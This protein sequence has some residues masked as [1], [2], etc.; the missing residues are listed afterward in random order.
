MLHVS[1]SVVGAM[2]AALV[3]V[4]ASLGAQQ[5]APPKIA[6]N[7]DREPVVAG[8][9]F[10]FSIT[11]ETSGADEPDIK[12]PLL[13]NMRILRQ[14]ESHPMSLSFSFGL[15]Q[16][17]QAYRSQQAVYRYVLVADNPGRYK[18]DPV[19]VTVGG[20]RYKSEPF[21]IDVSAGSGSP[22]ARGPNQS[23][24]GAEPSVSGVPEVEGET[25]EGMRPNEEYV[26]Q[27]TASKKEAVVGEKIVV[28]VVA[29]AA[30]TVADLEI[31]R[32]PGTEGFW[33]E[34]LL[35]ANRRVGTEQVLV[36]GR[37]FARV[38]MRRVAV[39]P[40]KPGK[41]TIEPAVG[42]FL[43]SRGFFTSGK[44]FTRTSE[45]IVIDVSPLPEK[46]R[47][48]GF[49]PANVGRFEFGVSV[50]STKVKVG[51]PVTVT[52]TVRG[53]GNLRSLVLPELGDVAGFKT[54]EPET[55][56]QVSASGT[57]VTGIRTVKTLMIAKEPGT[58]RIL[59]LKWSYFDPEENR[60]VTEESPEV[61]IEVTPGASSLQPAV[62]APRERREVDAPTGEERLNRKLR[63]IVSRSELRQDG[64]RPPMASGWFWGLA[65]LG[66][67]VYF[68]I[69]FISRTRRRL[70][71]AEIKG[72]SKRADAKALRSL[73]AL[74][75]KSSELDAET[76]FAGLHKI[77]IG[78]LEARLET[79]VAGDTMAEL[80][81]RL[82]RRGFSEAQAEAVVAELE[83]WDFARFARSA[84]SE[85]ERRQSGARLKELVAEMA[86]VK[87]KNEEA[88]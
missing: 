42:Q 28:E 85:S 79:P 14:S 19:E 74:E 6:M 70:L 29:Y 8:Q 86:K 33:V 66:P 47:P 77:F 62:T 63:S 1:K 71:E 27:M 50:D 40:I 49:D 18:I 38:L 43:V 58:H 78:F 73:A 72:R 68:G 55:D 65:L 37:R 34:N 80:R 45:P 5:P 7:V 20:R 46:T 15:G 54:Y 44:R 36:N 16:A 53:E 67:C 26:L 3:A 30:R 24:G 61:E 87:L 31:T 84:A 10:T 9:P 39:F 12:L 48:E 88:P 81:A 56:T 60:Y 69:L 17:Q 76:Y 35:P 82:G 32:E 52:M 25:L 75:K 13:P 4:P 64:G 59:G 21:V 57:S 22:P 83:A 23:G 2:M 41:L 11:I 51:E